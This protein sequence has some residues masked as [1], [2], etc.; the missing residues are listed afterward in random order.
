MFTGIVSDGLIHSILSDDL[1]WELI[2]EAAS[3]ANLVKIGD[4]VAIDGA[5]L[6]VIKIQGNYLS[7]Y[8]STESIDKT[9]IRY[10]KVG[11]KINIELP[12][13]PNGYLGGHYVLG[14]VDATAKVAKIIP[15]EK[16]WFF[17]ITVPE[18]FV[19]YVVYKGSIAINGISLTINKV[20]DNEIELCIIPVTIAKTNMSLL[21]VGDSVNI[22]FDILAK[23]TEQ[24]LNKREVKDV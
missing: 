4:S 21:N 19:K 18:Q 15:G 8:V 2:I 5:C 24:L 6:S 10:Y 1:G 7:F 16:A 13:Q 11:D 12:M 3:F 20:V 9:I 22:E 23:Y 14:H 17:N